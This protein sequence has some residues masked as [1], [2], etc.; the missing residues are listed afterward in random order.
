MVYRARPQ[1]EEESVP[2]YGELVD[3]AIERTAKEAAEDARGRCTVPPWAFDKCIEVQ[4]W[5]L[6]E[7]RLQLMNDQDLYE[8]GP[9]SVKYRPMLLGVLD[10][11]EVWAEIKFKPHAEEELR[12]MQEVRISEEDPERRRDQLAHEFADW[13]WAPVVEEYVEI[14]R[15]QREAAVRETMKAVSGLLEDYTT[16][17]RANWPSRR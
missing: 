3:E 16:S 17:L 12:E 11:A 2:E 9:Y 6:G 7:L 15:E 1:T 8:Q 4:D 14:P 5:V 13:L 10:G